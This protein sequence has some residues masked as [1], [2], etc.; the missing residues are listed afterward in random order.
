MDKNKNTEQKI[1]D[2]AKKVFVKYGYDGTRMQMI[3][4]EA[5]INKAMLHY[6]YRSKDKL[7]G[8]IFD[9]AFDSFTPKLIQIFNSDLPLEVTI[10]EFADKYI[11]FIQK[12]PY[13]PMFILREVQHNPERIKNKLPSINF[14]ETLFVKKLKELM[15]KKEIR[16]ITPMELFTNIIGLCIFPFVS[17]NIVKKFFNKSDEE[18]AEFL[19]SRKRAIPKLIME[20]IK[21]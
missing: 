16:E 10:Y 5:E 3:A 19:E 2:A 9:D 11:T 14:E 1:L 18:Y 8:Q 12:N 7:F 21:L 13:V 17:Q 6:Y 15:D 4:D 20:G